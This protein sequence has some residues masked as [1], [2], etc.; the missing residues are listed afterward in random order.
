MRCP[1]TTTRSL[2]SAAPSPT[3][4]RALP[5]QDLAVLVRRRAI[6]RADAGDGARPLRDLIARLDGCS[7]AKAGKIVEAAGS[8]A[9]P[10]T[11][12]PRRRTTA[13][14][15]T[16][17]ECPPGQPGAPRLRRTVPLRRRHYAVA[18]GELAVRQR[19]PKAEIPF[20]V[21][22]WA[23]NHGARRAT[24][25]RVLANRTPVT[26][27]INAYRDGDK[28]ICVFGCGLLAASATPDQGR[29][30]HHAEHHDAV[31][32]DHLGRQGAGPRP[33]LRR[34]RE[35]SR[36]GDAQGAARRAE[37][38]DACRRRMSCSRISTRRSRTSAATAIPLQRAADLVP[39]ASD[40]LG[41]DRQAADD[42]QLQDIITDYENE[43]G[44]IPGMYR[45]PRG[46]IYHPHRA[47]HP[48]RH[49]HR[50][51]LRAPGLAFNKL[52]YIEKEGFT[53]AL[54]DAAGRSATTAR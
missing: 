39:A 42:R 35:R 10:A 26:A 25:N 4:G 3:A 6:P 7:G 44:P 14:L 28:E 50:R 43:H 32:A 54:K 8:T 9:S 18:R 52:V 51:G 22:A 11:T 34:D 38:A 21:E 31:Y 24:S 41:G 29:L 47:R 33:F 49:A 5:R 13:L 15:E 27:E 2:G 16:A 19:H 48:A 37:G 30:R 40:R 1:P 46:S 17:R 20:L 45:E 53:E 23:R 36:Q 12:S